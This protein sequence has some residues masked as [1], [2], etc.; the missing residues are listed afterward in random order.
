LDTCRRSPSFTKTPP[1]LSSSSSSLTTRRIANTLSTPLYLDE[2]PGSLA[3]PT[4]IAFVDLDPQPALASA[5]A[6]SPD[7]PRAQL[8][9]GACVSCTD[10]VEWL[11]HYTPFSASFP[12]PIRLLPATVGSD[13]LPVGVGFL[14]VPAL[15]PS[16]FL[17]VRT[18]YAPSLR[19][20]VL[21]ERDFASAAGLDISAIAATQL[22]WDHSAGTFSFQALSSD[23][24]APPLVVVTGVLLDG[25]AYT[26]SLFLPS[27][28]TDPFS[29]STY[30]GG[31]PSPVPSRAI[32]TLLSAPPVTSLPP[33]HT[34]LSC[35]APVL[36][37]RQDT[38]RLLWHQRLG[39]PSDHYLFNA[40]KFVKGVPKFRHLD[41][42]MDICP[43]CIRAKQTKSP[44]GPNT[45]RVATLPFQGLSVDFSF[46]GVRS[47]DTTRG[48]EYIGFNGE[49]C[50]ILVVDHFTRFKTGVTR[51]SKAAP[52]DWLRQF[53]RQHAPSCS[54]KYVHLD[55]GG[56]L[57]ANPAIRAL[58]SEFGYALRPTG[59]D[60]S[61]QNGPVERAHLTVA[62]AI[63]ALLT[64][65]GL[66][67]R[68]WPYAFQHWL[69]ICN[70]LPSRDQTASPLSLA[71]GKVDDFSHFRTFGCRVWV[72]PPGRRPAKF[73]PNSAKGTF[74]G[75]LPDTTR[76]ILWFD[77]LT[78]HVKIAS[79]ARFD[80]GMNDLPRP[81]APPN[82]VHLERT[83]HGDLFP[84]EPAAVAVSPFSCHSSPFSKTL[85]KPLVVQCSRHDFGLTLATDDLNNRCFVANVVPNS[86]AALLFS[87]LKATRN[88]IR[89][90]YLVRVND[91]D[92]F[93]LADALAC[94]RELHDRGAASID[95]V[96]APEARQTARQLASAV[97]E[98]NLFNPATSMDAPLHTLTMA[99]VHAIS[100]VR[101]PAVDDDMS[102]PAPS[103]ALSAVLLAIRSDATTPA[104]QA[105]KAFTRRVLKPLDTWPLWFAGEVKQL[106][107]FHALGMF[108][109]PV[110]RPRDA[111]VLRMHWQYHI[112][113]CGT[114]RARLCC[115]GS[116]R[117]APMLHRLA[118]TYSSCVEQNIQRLFFALCVLLNYK[119]YGGDAADAFAHSPPP[120]TPTFVAIDDAYFEW[121]LLRFGVRLDRSLVL[122]VQHALQGHPESGRLWERHIN[123]ILASPSFSFKSTTHDR[124]IYS[125]V[126]RG[127][128]LLLLRQVDDFA[129]AAPSEEIAV[130]FYAQLGR[131]LQLPGESAPPFT[132]LGLIRDFN[133]IDVHQYSD[134]TVLSCSGYIDR[135]LRS[136]HWTTPSAD[137]ADPDSG[138]PLSPLP[139]DCI[140]SLYASVGPPESS[141]EHQALLARF[142]FSYRGLLGEILYAYVTCR[143]D[144]GYAAITLSKFSSAP[145]E[146]HFAM[147]KK[148]MKYLRRTRTWGIHFLRPAADP[149]LP[150]SPPLSL[151]A[152]SP[153]SP[154]PDFPALAPGARLT[155]FLDAAHGNDLR[156]RRSTTGFAFLLAGGCISYKC[157][158]QPIT[159]TSSTEAEFYA[160]V[161]ASKQ[162]LYL[163]SVLHELG[164]PQPD[165]TPLFCDNQSA[166]NMIN[167]RVPTDRSR[168]ILIQYFAIQDWKE[169]GLITLCHIPGV[170]NPADDLTK[171]LGWILH[172]RHARRL[173][174]HFSSVSSSSIIPISFSSSHDLPSPCPDQG[175]LLN[176]I[177]TPTS[178]SVGVESMGVDSVGVDPNALFKC[179]PFVKSHF[180]ASSPPVSYDRV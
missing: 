14:H 144:I 8:D 159:A 82:V 163:R 108:G 169:D 107:Q 155:G 168:H 7:G 55:Q 158:T 162:A 99:D 136:H 74:L 100:A 28:V 76:N 167:A 126:F 105:L 63:R 43:T 83:Q 97:K 44:A 151:P 174:G 98:L 147:L 157:K 125:G 72:R 37:L 84:A 175:R 113:R 135:V 25:K 106:D 133:G 10:H 16:G 118:Q 119:A 179:D 121:Y 137:E 22:L 78:D 64:G 171:P 31:S 69:R 128:P 46:S 115:D 26:H 140:A 80:E 114:R 172:S 131:E 152:P 53:L 129:L 91:V 75:F 2:P 57:Y 145:S 112:K 173:M 77:P 38:E 160:A 134:R 117:A 86:S 50:W 35:A 36:A 24:Q 85:S 94:L 18:F 41:A 21:D 88:K 178:P 116:L 17:A 19:A 79:H 161:S 66:E 165:P 141:P 164:F 153:G 104:E 148:L 177:G 58:F 146:F 110:P 42:V 6:C 71:F 45:T 73:L 92:V 20:T 15:T 60:A 13:T 154:L 149:S 51:V 124:S 56:E 132:Y 139:P 123:S 3:L 166:I 65:A 52:V 1:P 142:G 30:S 109:D 89:G 32:Q 96:F 59:A 33:P 48:S 95:L 130:A 62:N 120:E 103:P 29:V 87:S 40:H 34:Y 180:L 81:A 9:T 39:H 54:G 138:P 143:P 11:H 61:H 122:P 150:P 49:T 27:S 127:A 47:S 101:L 90:A 111:V 176:E 67:V 170:I 5:P 93:T 23:P 156:H 4:S 102:F 70:S 12:C 68:F